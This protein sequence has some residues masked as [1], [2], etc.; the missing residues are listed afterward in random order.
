MPL[1]NLVPDNGTRFVAAV[2]KQGALALWFPPEGGLEGNYQ[3]RL[4]GA[5][6]RTQLLSARGLGDLSRFLL[7]SH[8]VRPA[9]LGKKEKRVFDLPPELAI[10]MDNLPPSARGFVLWLIEGKV[11]SLAELEYL[12]MLPAA[13]AKLKIVIELGSDRGIRWLPLAEAVSKMAE[14]S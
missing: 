14:G 2:E 12:S 7:E 8:G 10:Y 3:R 4:R 11:L 9:H 1:L 6:Y 5:G 13:V